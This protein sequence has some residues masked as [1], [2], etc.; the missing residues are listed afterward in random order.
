MLSI[1]EIREKL[2]DRNL[3][4][5]ARRCE[6]SYMTVYNMANGNIENPGYKTIKT[7]VDYLEGKEDA[8]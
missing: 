8:K 2:S 6:M 1:D 5:V 7:L 4:E 3:R